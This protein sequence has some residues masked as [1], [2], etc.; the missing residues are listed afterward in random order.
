MAFIR[1]GNTLHLIYVKEQRNPAVWTLGTQMKR[2]LVPSKWPKGQSVM[3]RLYW[4]DVATQ[5]NPY[6]LR[7]AGLYEQALGLL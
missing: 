4:L 7:L 2:V 1:V 6:D 5:Q 3:D